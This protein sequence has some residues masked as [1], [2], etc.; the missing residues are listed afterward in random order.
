MN[1]THVKKL[2]LFMQ[3]KNVTLETRILLRIT[4]FLD[5]AH[6]PVFQKTK[7]HKVSETGSPIGVSSF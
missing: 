1:N 2:N 7:Q 4:G 3:S 6:C 5:F